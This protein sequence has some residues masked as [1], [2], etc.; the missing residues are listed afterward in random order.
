MDWTAKGEDSVLYMSRCILG[1]SSPGITGLQLHI[2]SPMCQYWRTNIL[3]QSGLPV[4]FLVSKLSLWWQWTPALS[5]D[6]TLFLLVLARVVRGAADYV[7]AFIFWNHLSKKTCVLSAAWTLCFVSVAVVCRGACVPAAASS[8]CTVLLWESSL[9]SASVLTLCWKAVM[10]GSYIYLRFFRCSYELL[11]V[12]AARLCWMSFSKQCWAV[13]GFNWMKGLGKITWGCL[14]LTQ[15]HM[16]SVYM[17]ST[18]KL[19]LECM[20]LLWAWVKVPFLQHQ[21]QVKLQSHLWGVAQSRNKEL[22]V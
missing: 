4:A 18:L 13:A 3:T 19:I 20:L 15:F 21:Y 1:F 6:R 16:D 22:E 17:L 12:S 2:I 11:G 10:T 14:L 9:L 7:G 8:S 5:Q